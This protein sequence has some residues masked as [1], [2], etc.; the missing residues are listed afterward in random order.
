MSLKD[1]MNY[2][3]YI[4]Y[5]AENLQFYLWHE[6]YTKKFDAL[7][8]AVKCLSPKWEASMLAPSLGRA[9]AGRTPQR[10]AFPLD[11]KD[12]GTFYNDATSDSPTSATSLAHSAH[13]LTKEQEVVLSGMSTRDESDWEACRSTPSWC[14]VGLG[15]RPPH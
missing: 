2:L 6:E 4:A 11:I 10:A 8:E 12:M 15:L 1:F 13:T 5:D 7:P 14:S 3:V 9:A